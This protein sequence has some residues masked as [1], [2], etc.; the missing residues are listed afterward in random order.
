ME[1]IVQRQLWVSQSII[2][3]TFKALLYRDVFSGKEVVLV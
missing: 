1:D 3:V 2:I